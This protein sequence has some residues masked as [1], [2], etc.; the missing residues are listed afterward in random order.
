MAIPV[1]AILARIEPVNPSEFL[2]IQLRARRNRHT[3][4][5]RRLRRHCCHARLADNEKLSG[6]AGLQVAKQIRQMATSVSNERA[7]RAYEKVGF[8]L[9]REFQDP[10]SGPC[11]YMLAEIRDAV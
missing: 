8:R 6:L 7:I 2:R 4:D 11:R 1:V 3:P 5:E 10:E 9:F